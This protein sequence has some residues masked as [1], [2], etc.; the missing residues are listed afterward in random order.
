MSNLDVI[1]IYLR[2]DYVVKKSS[3]AI[4]PQHEDAWTWLL[5]PP[6]AMRAIGSVIYFINAEEMQT[7]LD[8]M[9]AAGWSYAEAL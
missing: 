4:Q 5:V 7:V 9:D 8:S 2:P 3:A 1:V 6:F